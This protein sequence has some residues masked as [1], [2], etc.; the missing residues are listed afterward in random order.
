MKTRLFAF[1]LLLFAFNTSA[2]TPAQVQSL[3]DSGQCEQALQVLAQ[4]QQSHPNQ[5]STIIDVLFID[6][7]L[8]AGK[9]TPDNAS[10]VLTKLKKIEQADP[11]LI[12]VNSS[13]FAQLKTK[14]KAIEA[15][16]DE[17]DGFFATVF[18]LIIAFMVIA[19]IAWLIS[20]V[21]DRRSSGNLGE[22]LPSTDGFN[23]VNTINRKNTVFDKANYLRGVIENQADK[24]RLR[25][26][27]VI[28]TKLARYLASVD[29][30]L[31]SL[32]GE[33]S[34]TEVDFKSMEAKL[35]NWAVLVKTLA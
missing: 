8:C 35:N 5:H 33:P 32:S 27:D 15:T 14:I 34:L 3:I 24:A 10:A 29:G 31:A 13:D 4:E 30:L 17:G 26:D 20:F 12:G 1:T 2:A 22:G 7:A 23:S 28:A 18:K 9:V 16:Q 25:G 21:L 11:L 6:A 19:G